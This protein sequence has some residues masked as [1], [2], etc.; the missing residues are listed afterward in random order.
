MRK[1]IF[2]F[3]FYF[4]SKRIKIILIKNKLIKISTTKQPDRVNKYREIIVLKDINYFFVKCQLFKEPV[5]RLHI[6]R[7]QNKP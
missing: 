3:G 5:F 7:S 2:C 6:S 1:I 4:F